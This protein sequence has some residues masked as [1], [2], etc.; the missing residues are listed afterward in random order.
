MYPEI[1][2]AL[3]LLWPGGRE[4]G[5]NLRELERTQWLSRAQ[6][7]ALQLRKVQRVVTCAYQHVPFYRERYEVQGIHPEDITSLEDLQVVDRIELTPASKHRLTISEVK[8]DLA[9]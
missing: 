8:P 7:E 6:V 5:R 2:R 3:R 4:T 9:E 1:Y